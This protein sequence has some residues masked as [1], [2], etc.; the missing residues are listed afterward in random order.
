MTKSFWDFWLFLI[1]GGVLSYIISFLSHDLLGIPQGVPFA[2]FGITGTIAQISL[3]LLPFAIS[4][5]LA[6]IFYFRRHRRSETG[7]EIVKCA[8]KIGFTIFALT[9]LYFVLSGAWFALVQAPNLIMIAA[10]LFAPSL[11]AAAVFWI[12]FSATLRLI[13]RWRSIS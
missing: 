12:V 4:A 5:S 1:P 7:Q 10:V 11:S 13:T 8:K 3:L 9:I 6:A 2:R